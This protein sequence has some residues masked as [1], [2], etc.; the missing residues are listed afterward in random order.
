MSEP[1]SPEER[2]QRALDRAEAARNARAAEIAADA[3]AMRQRIERFMSASTKVQ[4]K[5]AAII[6]HWTPQIEA[7]PLAR[8][9]KHP[10][11]LAHDIEL[12]AIQSA[13]ANRLTI[14]SAGCP[15]CQEEADIRRAESRLIR[16]GIP[17]RQIGVRLSTWDANWEP[18]FA[19]QRAAALG[20]VAEWVDR[21][22]NPFLVILGA[23]GGTG[24]TAL[25]VAALRALST[26]FR[27]IEYRDW[28]SATLAMEF[29]ERF[30][31]ISLLRQVG[32]LLIDDFGNRT[33]GGKDAAGGN[34]FERDIMGQILNHRFEQRLPTI[35]TTNLDG[36]AFAGRLDDRT[37][38]RI[39]AGRLV[40]DATDWP[41]KRQHDA[42]I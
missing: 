4:A 40:I 32:A 13:K 8:C 25:G 18:V 1:L 6:A 37:V 10:V 29:D 9:S 15:L 19:P 12:S 11:D 28:F 22:P 20:R 3:S 7:A 35:L 33:T 42:G 26:D 27:C 17:P 5:R 36:R 14:V 31:E 41:S 23:R 21:R 30:A 39:R 38:D 16:A 34:L 24:K 2:R